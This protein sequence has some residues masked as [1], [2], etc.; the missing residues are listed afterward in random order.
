MADFKKYFDWNQ[1][2]P[3]LLLRLGLLHI[4][5]IAAANYLVQFPENTWGIDWSWGMWVFP[6]AVVATDLTVRLTNKHLA[7]GIVAVA[8]LP[9]IFVSIL[10]A[11]WRIG[12]A[13]GLAYFIGQLL[14]VSVFQQIRERVGYW[15]AAPLVSTLAANVLDT[16]LFYGLAFHQGS[17]AFMAENWLPIA[18]TDLLLKIVTSTVVFLPLYGV[19]LSYLKGRVQ[20]T[21]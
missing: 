6:L 20:V 21:A 17:D 4:G 16:Y 14:D 8:F 7:R 9:A 2:N 15:W 5:I 19:L 18:T 11:N 3:T 10:L 12:L 13:S 1:V